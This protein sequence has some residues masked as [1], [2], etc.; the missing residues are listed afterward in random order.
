MMRPGLTGSPPR[1][2]AC[3]ACGMLERSGRLRVRRLVRRR[4]VAVK[5]LVRRRTSLSGCR[6]GSGRGGS[7]AVGWA[8]RS[9]GCCRSPGHF[10]PRSAELS[11][12][13]SQTLQQIAA[14]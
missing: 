10:H 2:R 4:N 13:D 5:R 14:R 7:A 9:R 11:S 6:R 1:Q 3:W 8:R 12:Q